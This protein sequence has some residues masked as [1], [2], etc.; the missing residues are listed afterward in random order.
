MKEKD[1]LDIFK[2]YISKCDMLT[3][4]TLKLMIKN[5]IEGKGMKEK[6]IDLLE[7]LTEDALNELGFNELELLRLRVKAAMLKLKAKPYENFHKRLKDDFVEQILTPPTEEQ[8]EI[9]NDRAKLLK[10]MR[11]EKK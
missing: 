5:T 3:L 8:K 11:T 4:K 7:I 9:I 2:D 1:L 10:R 6:K